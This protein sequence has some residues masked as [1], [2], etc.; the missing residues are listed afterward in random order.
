MSITVA[1]KFERLGQW[2]LQ[3]KSIFL[4]VNAPGG[5]QKT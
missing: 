5:L 2:R 4:P 3:Q 1:K